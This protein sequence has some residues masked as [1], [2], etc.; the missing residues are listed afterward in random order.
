MVNLG[1]L[2]RDWEREGRKC[3]GR[4]EKDFASVVQKNEAVLSCHKE[5]PT[6][7]GTQLIAKVIIIQQSF[8]FL[9]AL[10]ISLII[11][12]VDS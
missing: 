8:H 5:I 10:I 12:I 11:N 9:C 1:R 7:N 3:I 2:G 6:Q 4:R